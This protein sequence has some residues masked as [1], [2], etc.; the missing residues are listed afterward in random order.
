MLFRSLAGFALVNDEVKIASSGRWMDQFFVVRKYRRMGAGRV[1]ARHAFVELPGH[2]EV[3]QILIN[4]PA[5][6][7][8]RSVI[9]EF[10]NGAYAER[11]LAGGSWEGV[12]QSF[13]SVAGERG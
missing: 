3:G 1:L 9:G 10:T 5:Q 2:W 6:A 4:H 12:V 11:T 13:D 7:F 8:W